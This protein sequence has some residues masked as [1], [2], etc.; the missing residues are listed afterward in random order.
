MPLSLAPRLASITPSLTLSVDDRVR[1][2]VAE[3]RSIVNL[4]VGQPDFDTPKYIADAGACAIAEGFTRYT[5]PMGIAE[6]RKAAAAWFAGMSGIDYQAAEIVVCSGSKH[7]LFNALQ[8]VVSPGEEV[9]VPA[10]YW[11][12]YPDLVRMAEGEPIHPA[13][14]LESGY[15]ITADAL[16]RSITRRTRAVILN[17]PNNPSGAVFT[18]EETRALARV[19]LEHDLVLISDEIYN[20]IT[21]DAATQLPFAAALPGMKERTITINGVSK[22]Y[23]MTGWRLGFAA[24]PA[25]VIE[26]MGRY[27]AQATGNPCSISQKAA[28]AAIRDAGPELAMMRDAYARRRKLVME[29]LETIPLVD[30]A[31]PLGAFYFLLR[32]SRTFGRH[33]G[34]DKVESAEDLAGLLLERGVA[35]VPGTG[36]GAPDSLRLSFAASDADLKRGLSVLR[37]TLHLLEPAPV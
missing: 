7:A 12:S 31:P 33:L 32:I 26:A 20:Q 36:F 14:T 10:P 25:E 1:T 8:A 5:S 29:E 11:V 18:P 30:Y 9:I 27:Q 13:A 2:L 24:G 3:G 4:T 21:Y 28:L 37:D 34:P 22:A 35:L 23:A 6:L 16:R 15:K 19:I 17:S